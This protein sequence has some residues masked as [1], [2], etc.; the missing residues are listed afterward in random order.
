MG[1]ELQPKTGGDF[2]LPQILMVS[3]RKS[4]DYSAIYSP[5]LYLCRRGR[6][7]YRP[8]WVSFSFSRNSWIFNNLTK[9]TTLWISVRAALISCKLY[10]YYRSPLLWPHDALQFFLY[11]EHH[12]FQYNWQQIPYTE[13]PYRWGRTVLFGG[14][15]ERVTNTKKKYG[16]LKGLRDS[17]LTP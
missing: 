15:N 13:E 16:S 4:A 3:W 7:H 10:R 6:G 2:R 17:L 5:L 11:M 14:F 9:K 8:Y 1:K 12:S